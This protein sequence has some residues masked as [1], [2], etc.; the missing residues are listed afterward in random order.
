MTIAERLRQQGGAMIVTIPRD[1]ATD[2]GWSPGTEITVEKKG[3]SVNLR[4]TEHKPRGRLTV[5]Q[6]LSQIDES[7]ITELNQSTEG[8][9]EGKKGNEAW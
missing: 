4:A 1:L 3:D 9:A 7:E 6:L 5:A 8:W 2:P